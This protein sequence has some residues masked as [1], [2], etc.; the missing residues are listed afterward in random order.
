MA[1]IFLVDTGDAIVFA[2]HVCG[3]SCGG[4]LLCVGFISETR[5][6]ETWPG[7]KGQEHTVYF[8]LNYAKYSCSLR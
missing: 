7:K 3:G 1:L 6:L 2:L 4:F 8:Y 5:I